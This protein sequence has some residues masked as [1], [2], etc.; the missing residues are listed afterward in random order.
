VPAPSSPGSPFR[1]RCGSLAPATFSGGEQQRV[2]IARGLIAERP[3]LLL[4]E[5]TAALDAAN[6]KTV[7][8]LIG[9]ARERGC[10]RSSGSFTTARYAKLSPPP[11]SRC[12]IRKL[13]H[14]HRGQFLTNAVVVTAGDTFTGTVVMRG[15]VHRC[16]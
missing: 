12:N 7:I 14:E 9:E 1:G 3:I 8:Q 5:P 10:P 15:R 2:N 4:D 13:P 6:R 16:N 11:R